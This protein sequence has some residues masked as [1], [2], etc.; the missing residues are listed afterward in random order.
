MDR[1]L[2]DKLFGAGILPEGAVKQMEQWQ[3]V[4]G[5]SSKKMGRFNPRKIYDLRE[6]LELQA[7][8][9]LRETILDLDKIM[10][11]SRSVRL[12]FADTTIEGISAGVDIL[13]RYIIQIPDTAVEYHMLSA[14]VRPMAEIWDQVLRPPSDNRT[15]T[16][17][18]VLYSTIREGESV[19]THWF[20]STESPGEET[21][22]R[23]R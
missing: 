22:V 2:Q 17:V 15:I 14:V 16:D 18:S 23:S 20:C 19:P 10:S 3:T 4:R 6:D 21:L 11:R 12:S 1:K 5:G 8:P 13:K 7:L 9:V